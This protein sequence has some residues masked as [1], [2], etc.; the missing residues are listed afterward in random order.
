MQEIPSQFA[1]WLE[2][3]LLGEQ[4]AENDVLDHIISHHII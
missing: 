3:G 1:R 2:I 4:A